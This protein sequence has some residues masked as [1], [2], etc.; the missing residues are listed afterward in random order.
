M[1]EFPPTQLWESSL[2]K[3]CQCT[4]RHVFA[5]WA[6][7]RVSIAVDVAQNIVEF[8]D[9]QGNC[10]TIRHYAGTDPTWNVCFFGFYGG[11]AQ[12]FESNLPVVLSAPHQIG[13]PGYPL[14]GAA[15]AQKRELRRQLMAQKLNVQNE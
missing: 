2:P 1:D 7:S 11:L 12:G 8:K 13:F 3:E 14:P 6:H 9:E 10:F 15:A 4:Q 5:I